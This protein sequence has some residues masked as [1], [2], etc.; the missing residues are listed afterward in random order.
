M[1]DI[2]LRSLS[3]LV[4]LFLISYFFSNWSTAIKSHR[5]F[6]NVIWIVIILIVKLS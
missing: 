4:Y 2:T 3:L 6:Y 5:E 1:L